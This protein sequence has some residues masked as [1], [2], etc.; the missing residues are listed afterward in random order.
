MVLAY[1]TQK[2]N[3]SHPQLLTI[4]RFPF[5][6]VTTNMDKYANTPGGTI[7]IL[8]DE[9]NRAGKLKTGTIILFIA[10]G[11]G[12]TWGASIIKWV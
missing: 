4:S 10:I 2:N 7:P 9:V 1:G 12:W 3:F 8:L 11:A 5:E 6:K